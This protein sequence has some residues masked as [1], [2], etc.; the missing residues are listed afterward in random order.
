MTDPASSAPDT[1]PERPTQSPAP[2]PDSSAPSPAPSAASTAPTERGWGRLLVAL[3]A[4]IF[5]PMIPQIRALLP[6][7][8]T[9]VL[10]VP[11]VAACAL[12]G[13]W[14]GGRAFLAI[15]WV[16]IAV[17]LTVQS[18]AGAATPDGGAFYNLS[19][20][21][22]LLL[23][24]AFGLVCLFAEERPMFPRA[25]VALGIT[26]VLAGV[27]SMLGP[28]TLSHAA[29][30]V[31]QEYARRN[32]ETMATVN[33]VIQSHQKEWQDLASKVPR[34]N[35]LP[36]E[37]QKELGLISQFGYAVFPAL[38][39]LESLAALALAW[40]TYHR[41]GRTRL[42]APLRPL[43]EFRFNDQLVWGLIVGLTVM[44]LPT[45]TTLRGAGKNLLMFFGALY[46]MRGFGVLSWFMAPGSLGITLGV[47]FIMLFAPVL[48]AVAAL[49]F[50]LLG[51]AALALGLGDTW[52]DWRRRARP[53]P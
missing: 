36:A 11:A 43:R 42:G 37:T 44:L 46:A 34:L 47:G 25:L 38:L 17:L 20:G 10:F 22:S 49:V 35:Q 31:A 39:A 7:E 15:A 13:W 21:W 29:G 40:A 4:F 50:M 30:T 53:S 32:A 26:L 33:G 51:V 14:A 27:M 41:L 6:I 45:L 8:E 23:A 28:V 12:V 3:A 9:M 18:T 48:N 5:V 52:A 24:G 1:P 2:A 16:A 19:R